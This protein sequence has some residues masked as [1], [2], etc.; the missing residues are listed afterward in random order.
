MPPHVTGWYA[1]PRCRMLKVF[2][3]PFTKKGRKPAKA[4]QLS[5]RAQ[6][7]N[8]DA[9][10]LVTTIQGIAV[11]S[12]EEARTGMALDKLGFKYY[13]QYSVDFGRQRIGGQVL[14]FLVK[15]PGKYTIVDVR[16]AY[17]HT[18][19]KDDSLSIEEAAK[20]HNYNLLPFWDYQCTSVD[21]AV[22]FLRA[23]LPQA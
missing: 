22:S 23:H 19:S 13:Y 8:S 9:E 2:G 17:W 18:G 5:S 12:K 4:K 15:T 7:I 16:G 1:R 10:V 3:K 14:D 11:G 21:A 20:K 6:P